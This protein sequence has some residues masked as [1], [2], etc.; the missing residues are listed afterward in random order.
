MTDPALMQAMEATWPPAAIRRLGP[1]ILRDGQ[2]GGKRVSAA[3]LDG[4]FDPAAIACA[5]G[6]MLAAGLRPLFQLDPSQPALD[7]ALVARGYALVDP[8]VIYAADLSDLPQ[9]L[10][11]GMTSFPHWPPLGIAADLWA[12][13]GIGPERLAV[14]HRATG[15][16]TAILGRSRDR[17]AGVVFVALHG[18]VA[19]L[20]AL[21]VTAPA[22]RR[23][24]GRSLLAAAAHWA[25]GVGAGSLS[26]AVTTANAPARALYA[27][28][29]LRAVGHYHYRQLAAGSEAIRGA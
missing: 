27:S 17:A 3:S 24:T 20:H 21:E 18:P 10:P 8:V 23:G 28:F 22:R 11:P 26:L 13:G 2:G 29:G 5:E 4:P 14:M 7:A 16:K 25:R 19:M 15:P 9:D 1:W 6:A 12:E